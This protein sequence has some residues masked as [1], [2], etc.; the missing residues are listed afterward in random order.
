M[1]G[2]GVGTPPSPQSA[3]I[4]GDSLSIGPPV[5]ACSP[6]DTHSDVSSFSMYTYIHTYTNTYRTQ[7]VAGNVVRCFKSGTQLKRFT[8]YGMKYHPIFCSIAA[9]MFL[10]PILSL[11]P[12]CFER[13][14]RL[15]KTQVFAFFNSCTE[16]EQ[17]IFSFCHPASLNF[18]VR[19]CLHGLDEIL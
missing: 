16:D 5:E 2:A 10:K 12:E 6:R 3:V 19:V 13:D 1:Q 8:A 11:S 18:S 17:D 15:N 9:S 4:R 7:Q 14:K